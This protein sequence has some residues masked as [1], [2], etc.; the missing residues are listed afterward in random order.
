MTTHTIALI[1]AALFLALL[2]W[3]VAIFLRDDARREQEAQMNARLGRF[4]RR[5]DALPNTTPQALHCLRAMYRQAGQPYGA[6]GFA[7]WVAEQVAAFDAA[8]PQPQP[9]QPPD[10]RIVTAPGPR[11]QQ[12]R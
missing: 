2:A 3:E 7:R 4:V 12:K 6:S 10:P 9:P 8:P 5:D 11:Q 1:I